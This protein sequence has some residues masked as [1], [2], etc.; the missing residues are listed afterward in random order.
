MPARANSYCAPEAPT[1][2]G[3][4]RAAAFAKM[5]DSPLRVVLDSTLRTPSDAALFDGLLDG[6]AVQV[7]AR[8][9][10]GEQAPVEHD[11]GVQH[12]AACRHHLAEYNGRLFD[13]LPRH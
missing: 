11:V 6:A 13:A 1:V 8:P 2:T 9:R 4:K 3:S 7:A 12:D 10:V 5:L